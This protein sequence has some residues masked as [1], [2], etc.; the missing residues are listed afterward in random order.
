MTSADM[1]GLAAGLDVPV[2]WLRYGWATTSA[3]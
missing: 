2:A 1:R 3:T